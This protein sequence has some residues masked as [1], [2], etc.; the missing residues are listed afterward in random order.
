[1]RTT[2]LGAIS[3][4]KTGAG[5]P[6]GAGPDT[7][8]WLQNTQ[9]SAEREVVCVAAWTWVCSTTTTAKAAIRS[10]ATKLRIRRIT[11]AGR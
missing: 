1:M 4:R 10:T 7:T 6:S 5:S 3:T 9:A 11:G 8:V 2:A